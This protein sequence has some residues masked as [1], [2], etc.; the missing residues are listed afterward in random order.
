[1][2]L[3]KQYLLE[4]PVVTKAIHSSVITYIISYD[5]ITVVHIWTWQESKPLKDK[6][7]FKQQIDQEEREIIPLSTLLLLEYSCSTQPLNLTMVDVTK[8]KTSCVVQQPK[9]PECSIRKLL[10][11]A[12]IFVVSFHILCVIGLRHLKAFLRNSSICSVCSSFF[13]SF[14]KTHL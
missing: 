2:Q 11:E 1:M 9:A 8:G 12:A 14:S 7:L 13:I 5:R 6:S 3:Q 4:C 10:P